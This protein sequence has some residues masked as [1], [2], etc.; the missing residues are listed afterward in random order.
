V[1]SSA[2]S[3]S[4]NTEDRRGARLFVITGPSGVGKGTL[5]ARL[6]EEVPELELSVSATTRG[7]RGSERDGVHYH[8]MDAEE[9]ARRVADGQ[10]IEHAGYAS[11]DYGTLRSEVD[12]RLAEG[13]SVVL[14]IELQ[15]A[16]QIRETVPD[17]VQ[18][19]IAPPSPADLRRRLEGRGTDSPEQ[20]T[21]R[22]AVAAEELEARD[23]FGHVIENDDLDRASRELTQLVRS[24]LRS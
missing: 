2:T 8:F 7:P 21:N 3:S 15:G 17:A 4:G 5:I 11:H 23:E 18:V 9:F 6:L 20:I 13:R 10:F 14:E 12:P 1:S 19:F 22:L 16:R 24:H